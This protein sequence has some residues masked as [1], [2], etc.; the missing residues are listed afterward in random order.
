M[1]KLSAFWKWIICAVIGV[2]LA[3]LNF[4]YHFLPTDPVY[5]RQIIYV[6]S[7]L[8]GAIILL[9][10]DFYHNSKNQSEFL[11]LLKALN[12]HE[13]IFWGPGLFM[14]S[15]LFILLLVTGF[16][17]PW[18]YNDAVLMSLYQWYLVYPSMWLIL[19]AIPVPFLIYAIIKK[20]FLKTL[21]F[22]DLMM[23]PLLFTLD[24]YQR[25]FPKP[26]MIGYE[27][28]NYVGLATLIIFIGGFI[29]V[30]N[31]WKN[32]DYWKTEQKLSKY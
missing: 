12:K 3:L 5:I 29:F 14:V 6:V 22:L 1:T 17:L 28:Y 7:A 8:I 18:G 27:I 25:I 31:Y 11:R 10:H 2:G 20:S 21:I 23:F 15:A 32:R 4:K 30:F 26:W 9:Y 24:F 13:I 16:F 19:L